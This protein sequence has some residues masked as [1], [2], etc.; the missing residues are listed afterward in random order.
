MSDRRWLLVAS[1]VSS[2]STVTLT[3]AGLRALSLEDFAVFSLVITAAVLSASV[4]RAS[5]AEAGYDL[6]TSAGVL[7]R[8]RL[9][10][11]LAVALPFSTMVFLVQLLVVSQGLRL[12]LPGVGFATALGVAEVAK[13]RLVSA[14]SFGLVAC[15]DLVRFAIIASVAFGIG[16]S[17]VFALLVAAT[18]ASVPTIFIAMIGPTGQAAKLSLSQVLAAGMDVLVQRSGGQIAATILFAASAPILGAISAARF[19]MS[20]MTTLFTSAA[21]I[22]LTGSRS[23]KRAVRK[24]LALCVSVGLIYVLSLQVAFVVWPDLLRQFLGSGFS[25]ARDLAIPIGIFAISGAL[26]PVLSTSLRRIGR[27]AV[28]L[29]ARL[30]ASISLIVAVWASVTVDSA[31]LTVTRVGWSYAVAGVIGAVFWVRAF[32]QLGAEAGFRE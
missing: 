24:L 4:I 11:A 27:S 21:G 26:S 13:V 19:A 18:I 6:S 32:Q 28:S 10:V 17:S 3:W 23:N 30:G 1:L 14:S 25:P 31:S 16:T 29:R 22:A 8:Q 7:S 5:I 20:P 2:L 9:A 12:L 15:F